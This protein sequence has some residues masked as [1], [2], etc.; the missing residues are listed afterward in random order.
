MR[1]K[2]TCSVQS[3]VKLLTAPILEIS[4]GHLELDPSDD[5]YTL[6][7]QYGSLDAVPTIGTVTVEELPDV[8]CAP[9]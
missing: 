9:R 7:Y 4:G 6:R 5:A 2:W 1:M 8:W 3:C